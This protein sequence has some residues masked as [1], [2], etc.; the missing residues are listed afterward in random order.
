[1]VSERSAEDFSNKMG[2]FDA[3][4]ALVE[5]LVGKGQTFVIDAQLVE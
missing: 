3:G 4:E 5:T 2:G 1:M